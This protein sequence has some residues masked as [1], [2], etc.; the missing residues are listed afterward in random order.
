MSNISTLMSNVQSLMIMLLPSNQFQL[1][2][3]RV[4]FIININVAN[5]SN[6]STKILKHCT[7]CIVPDFTLVTNYTDN[8]YMRQHLMNLL[9]KYK[10]SNKKSKIVDCCFIY[11][12]TLLIFHYYLHSIDK[13]IPGSTIQL[14]APQTY[15]SYTSID[16]CIKLAT[17]SKHS[18]EYIVFVP[19][20]VHILFTQL[21]VGFVYPI[22]WINCVPN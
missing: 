14:I 9:Y 5:Y 21:G 3:T 18:I 17:Y 13:K 6:K 8:N 16:L 20:L 19:N 12:F 15:N 2:S 10:G 22:R 7:T 4:T 1:A 11:W